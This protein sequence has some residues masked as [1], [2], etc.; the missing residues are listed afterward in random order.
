MVETALGMTD[1]QIKLVTA[2]GQLALAAMVAY[3]AWQ[4]WRTARNKLKADLFDRRFKLFMEIEDA[5]DMALSTGKRQQGVNDLANCAREVKWV[6]GAKVER[7]FRRRVLGPLDEL[8]AINEQQESE[9][10]AVLYSRVVRVRKGVEE[11]PAALREV[12][13]EHLTLKH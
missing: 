10:N 7:E 9:R 13:D 2:A 1:L 3:V 5:L 6:F 8:K 11:A 12:F 4:Q